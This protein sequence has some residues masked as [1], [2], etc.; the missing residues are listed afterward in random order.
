MRRLYI[1]IGMMAVITAA[2]IGCLLY[3]HIVCTE[4][5]Q[6][7]QEIYEDAVNGDFDTAY[8]KST[9]FYSYWI[10]QESTMIL[11]IRHYHLDEI[12]TNAAKLPEYLSCQNNAESTATV[13]TLLTIVETIWQEEQPVFR[14]I[15]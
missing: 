2:S 11:I 8:E 7:L 9:Q 14:S 15:F 10:K 12:R 13:K 5:E 6:M 1:S 4:S 3:V